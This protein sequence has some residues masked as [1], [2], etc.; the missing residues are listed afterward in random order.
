MKEITVIVENRIGTLASIAEALG[1]AG[2]NIEAISAYGRGTEAIFRLVT[3][4]PTSAKKILDKVPGMK[5][6]IIADILTVKMP[7]RPGELGKL[8]RKLANRK[9]DLESVYIMGK[10][11]H[12]FTD[13]AVKPV[14]TQFG[15]AREALGIKD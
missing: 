14:E 12:E 1:G 13:V 8:T 3:T 4:D 5:E 11:D 2:V 9:I 15:A 10:T 6:L 7:N